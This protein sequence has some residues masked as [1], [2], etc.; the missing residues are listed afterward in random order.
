MR[1]IVRLGY[2]ISAVVVVL[3]VTLDGGRCTGYA[4][5]RAGRPSV[6]YAYKTV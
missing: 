4:N 2:Q 1:Y 3:L 6:V 5:G